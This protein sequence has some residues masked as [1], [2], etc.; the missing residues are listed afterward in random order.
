LNE[1]DR[2][3]IQAV[4]QSWLDEPVDCLELSRRSI[5]WLRYAGVKIIR[6]LIL[7]DEADVLA[8]N[9]MGKGCV[10]DIDT[11]LG[12]M[13]LRL[14][15]AFEDIEKGIHF[16]DGSESD[17]V[18]LNTPISLLDLSRRSRNALD[19]NDVQTLGELVR[20]KRSEIDTIPNLGVDSVSEILRVLKLHGLRLGMTLSSG[21]DGTE[22]RVSAST[23]ITFPVPQGFKSISLPQL[24]F[25]PRTMNCLNSV[26]VSNA[27]DLASQNSSFFDGVPN[28]GKK[29]L[30]EIEDSLSA[31]YGACDSLGNFSPIE[32]AKESEILNCI[33]HN[34]SAENSRQFI[35]A[36]WDFFH[37]FCEILDEKESAIAKSRI[38]PIE[39]Q[40]LTLEELGKKFEVSRERIRQIESKVVNRLAGLLCEGEAVRGKKTKSI[41][42]CDIELSNTWKK[43]AETFA[44][45]VETDLYAFT[46]QLCNIWDIELTE[47]IPVLP[48]VIV[49]FTR[50]TT[51]RLSRDALS[52][53]RID[54]PMKYSSEVVKRTKLSS[55][56]IGTHSEALAM[57]GVS[58][59]EDLVTNWPIDNSV[60][61][62]NIVNVLTK[63]E[64]Y[65]SG[66][67][68]L[69]WEEY[70][71]QLGL[72]DHAFDKPD[73]L[74]Q[75]FSQIGDVISECVPC[76]TT[77]EN[78]RK[79]FDMR[80]RFSADERPTLQEC[81]KKIVGNS[82]RGPRMKNIE[83]YTLA[84]LSKV[85]VERDFSSC[86]IWIPQWTL[87]HVAECYK[88]FEQSSGDYERFC[89]LLCEQF[90]LPKTI[91]LKSSDLLWGIFNGV[92][93]NRYF[94]QKKKTKL[95]RQPAIELGQRIKLI[96][97][98]SIH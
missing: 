27:F 11:A 5:K 53:S 95:P 15:M 72:K 9:N 83:T 60:S 98:R 88:S 71:F 91:V 77:W 21:A 66:E 25:S 19:K 46:G 93:P 3:E 14:G 38:L 40:H 89:V 82:S 7:L 24:G 75:L 84:R 2:N 18:S 4:D 57:K 63:A 39:G 67:G 65:L 31:L 8:M 51:T 61:S 42:I 74:K 22:A 33:P 59:I 52:D 85:F 86:H 35:A 48:L 12:R 50:S 13:G 20:L 97:F 76:L 56:R 96:G 68:N 79:V 80:T 10:Q 36:I 55:F 78:C 64:A 34:Y 32:Y 45:V 28:L 90:L 6:D 49:V 92:S 1:T 73:D 44:G 43:V 70:K 62:K 81:A 69:N 41:Y 94:H 58:T 87:D 47:L 29:S 37:Q 23:R 16:I 54:P 26:K 17:F 30:S